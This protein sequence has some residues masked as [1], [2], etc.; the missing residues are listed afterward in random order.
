VSRRGFSIKHTGSL[1][2]DGNAAAIVTVELE[3][4]GRG[5][6]AE[7]ATELNEMDRSSATRWRGLAAGRGR[8]LTLPVMVEVAGL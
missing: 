5:P 7:L 2:A 1:G 8:C 3:V 6:I 4:P